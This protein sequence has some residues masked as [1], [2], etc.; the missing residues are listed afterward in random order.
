MPSNKDTCLLFPAIIPFP[1]RV[2]QRKMAR[3]VNFYF[4]LFLHSTKRI[5]VEHLQ[6]IIGRNTFRK[7]FN[8]LK[9]RL[10]FQVI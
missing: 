7:I 1:V 4:Y 6:E 2:P 5:L 9:Y 10:M 3:N 8:F